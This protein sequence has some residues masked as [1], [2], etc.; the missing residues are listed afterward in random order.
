[1]YRKSAGLF[2]PGCPEEDGGQPAV[3]LGQ[4]NLMVLPERNGHLPSTTAGFAG[5]ADRGDCT[6]ILRA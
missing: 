6:C 2:E 4:V 1:M 3:T 5:T